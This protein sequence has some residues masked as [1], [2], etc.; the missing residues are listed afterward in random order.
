MTNQLSLNQQLAQALGSLAT[1]N[2]F[3]RP[4]SNGI[5]AGQRLDLD[6]TTKPLYSVKTD[7]SVCNRQAEP[8][9]LNFSPEA[10]LSISDYNMTEADALLL[11]LE[12]ILLA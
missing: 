9:Q 8:I 7:L 11:E 2:T 6:P 3:D 12:K 1:I 4:R 5:F 10:T